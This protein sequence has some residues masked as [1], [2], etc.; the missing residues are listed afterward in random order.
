MHVACELDVQYSNLITHLY[1]TVLKNLGSSLIRLDQGGSGTIDIDFS[2]PAQ[3]SGCPCN[4]LASRMSPHTLHDLVIP[5]QSG[6]S[7]NQAAFE[8][9]RTEL[10][11]S[12]CPIVGIERLRSKAPPFSLKRDAGFRHIGG[13]RTLRTYYT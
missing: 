8:A 2:H 4:P 11:D 12:V 5:V 6:P 3:S 9:A 13:A 7:K 1:C 10:L